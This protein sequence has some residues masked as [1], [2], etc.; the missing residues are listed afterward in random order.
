MAVK[1]CQRTK[2][3]ESLHSIMVLTPSD[4]SRESSEEIIDTPSTFNPLSW[5]IHSEPT[6]IYLFS[7]DAR[8][9]L[10]T[11]VFHA[12]CLKYQSITWPSQSNCARPKVLL[13]EDLKCMSKGK[14][15]K[16]EHPHDVFSSCNSPSLLP[17]SPSATCSVTIVC[18]VFANC[19]EICIG[20]VW[21]H[22]DTIQNCVLEII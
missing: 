2:W 19:I 10:S 1:K 8:W 13:S 17:F 18:S 12:M 7:V 5:M 3:T 20:L 16:G 11:L 22:F 14:L 15:K 4:R 9:H 21:F 6:F